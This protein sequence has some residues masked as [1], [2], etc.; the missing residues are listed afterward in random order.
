M[1]KE[2]LKEYLGIVTEMEQSCFFQNGLRKQLS[3]KCNLLGIPKSISHPIR[4]EPPS[5][6]SG[7]TIVEGLLLGIITWFF[8]G[9]I[10]YE[11]IDGYTPG[12]SLLIFILLGVVISCWISIS[13]DSAASKEFEKKYKE[14]LTSYNQAIAQDDVRVQKENLQK[15]ILKDELAVINKTYQSTKSNLDKIYEKNILYPKYRNFVAVCTMY[16]YV[17]SGRCA[18]LEGRDGAYNLYELESRMDKI[19]TELDHAIQAL[20]RIEKSQYMLF[21][22]IQTTN[23]QSKLMLNATEQLTAQVSKLNTNA[24]N[25]AYQMKIIEDHSTIHEYQTERITKELEYM[26]RLNFISGNYDNIIFP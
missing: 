7:R 1:N 17:C 21:K 25:I 10:L 14:A 13:K 5:F 18:E 24:E 26:N 12:T 6:F 19:V 11:I 2:Q 22:A 4:E 15:E 23:E 3:D 9:F 8:S 20:S 16:E